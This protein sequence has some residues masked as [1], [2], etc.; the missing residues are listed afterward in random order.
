ML[1][2]Q[3]KLTFLKRVKVN[4]EE[5]IYNSEL[6]AHVWE[7]KKML[8]KEGELIAFE[9]MVKAHKKDKQLFLDKLDLVEEEILANEKLVG[10]QPG[11][12]SGPDQEKK[13]D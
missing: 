3:G 9:T 7:R 5:Q 4:L 1:N 13:E 6:E 2:P 10:K 8:A 11:A 12:D